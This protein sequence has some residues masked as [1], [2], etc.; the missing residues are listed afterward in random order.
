MCMRVCA[1]VNECLCALYIY[2]CVYERCACVCVSVC[3]CA[4][5]FVLS[6]QLFRKLAIRF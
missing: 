2:A 4:C 5:Y 3:D 1:G 6:K